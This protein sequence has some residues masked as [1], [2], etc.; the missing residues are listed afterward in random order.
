MVRQAQAGTW[1]FIDRSTVDVETANQ[2]IRSFAFETLSTD[3]GMNV[4]VVH[5]VVDGVERINAKDWLRN[6]LEQGIIHGAV[7]LL[8]S[9]STKIF[10]DS[11][12]ETAD[13]VTPNIMGLFKLDDKVPLT[14]IENESIA[15]FV[16]KTI[17]ETLLPL[18]S[19]LV[20][21]HFA[22]ALDKEGKHFKEAAEL[23][24]EIA[25]EL[26]ET[27]Q[28]AQ[29]FSIGSWIDTD[30]LGT[31][32]SYEDDGSDCMVAKVSPA[33][34][35]PN[36]LIKVATFRSWR[37]PVF[38]KE[39]YFKCVLIPSL[40]HIDPH[41]P[42]RTKDALLSDLRIAIAPNKRFDVHMQAFEIHDEKFGSWI[43]AHARWS[44]ATNAEVEAR[45]KAAAG[46]ASC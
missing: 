25:S 6:L 32:I 36:R 26:R 35:L 17:A 44:D 2:F 21:P 23:A 45:R 14:Q 16:A 31:S 42:A 4:P 43:F 39:G 3:I 13:F 11:L 1:L 29:R 15:S 22:G 9:P 46:L 27:G 10:V 37:G 41:K 30:H 38:C 33:M 34:E 19:V 12:G 8:I 7:I 20:Y 5:F 28:S 18:R 40:Q 24:N